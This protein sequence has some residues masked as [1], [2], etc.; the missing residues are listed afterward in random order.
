MN[1]FESDRCA[2]VLY[3][4][5]RE[6]AVETGASTTLALGVLDG[7]R[8]LVGFVMEFKENALQTVTPFD[9]LSLETPL[10]LSTESF[11]RLWST[12]A[13][14]KPA[15]A[16]LCTRAMFEGLEHAEHKLN[17]LAAVGHT[18]SYFFRATLF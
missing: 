18:Q 6:S 2:R 11:E 10:R 4:L 12:L 7:K 16:L 1:A 13:A 8:V 9:A 14:F 3:A 15:A 17:Y 5:Y